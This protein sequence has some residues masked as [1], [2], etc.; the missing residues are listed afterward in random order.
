MYK[1]I[2]KDWNFNLLNIY[3]F[4]KSGPLEYYFK[5]IKKN[6][7]KLDGDLIEA[8]V[9]NG[10]SLLATAIFLK[11]LK[12]KK[13]IYAYDSW[14]GFPSSYKDHPFDK[15]YNWKKMLKQKIITLNHYNEIKKNIKILSF[16]KKKNSLN[17]FNLSSS[18]DFSNCS[19]NE[20]KNKIKFLNLDNIR[21]IKGDFRK[22][23][24][25]NMGP[26]KIMCALIDVD[27]YESYNISLPYIWDKL[28]KKGFI[29]LDEYYSLKFP[30]ARLATDN[31][32]KNKKQKPQ[33]LTKYKFDFERWGVFK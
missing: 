1:T 5:F 26:K 24:K 29:F 18:L 30:G 4:Y 13:I 6:F 11:K 23:M 25:S 16:L 27:L 8:G 14:E 17:S 12:S 19:I 33:V 31:F 7:N 22:T 3:N 32:F 21:L 28:N 10:K 15:F 20:L 9:H 2:D